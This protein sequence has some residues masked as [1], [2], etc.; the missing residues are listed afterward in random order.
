MLDQVHTIGAVTHTTV[1]YCA[2]LHAWV[3][4]NRGNQR[5]HVAKVIEV[6]EMSRNS[7]EGNLITTSMQNRDWLL[8]LGHQITTLHVMGASSDHFYVSMGT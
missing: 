8:Y 2:V 3:L 5:S 7:L 1:N 4:E 6:K